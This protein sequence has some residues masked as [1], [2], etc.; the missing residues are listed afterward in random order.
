[1]SPLW[2]DE[3]A[4]YLAPRRVT[5][6][7]LKRGVR[8]QYVKTQDSAVVGERI[9]GWDAAVGVLG[10]CLVDPIW[11]HAACRIIVA[12]HWMRFAIVPWSDALS[13]G[14]ERLLLAQHCLS[15]IYGDVVSQWCVTL[16][17]APPGRPQVACAMPRALL[18]DIERHTESCGLRIRSIQ[19]QL[20]AAFNCRRAQLPS[21]DGW[22]VTLE[23]GS[24]AAA[25]LSQGAW[26]AVRAV[27]TDN[28]WGVELRRLQTE[29]RLAGKE[30]ERIHLDAPPEFR[31][32]VEGASDS[33]VWLGA[34][35]GALDTAS[36]LAL[37]QR[38]YA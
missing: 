10:G 3:I 28:N 21:G 11:N 8:P 23:E 16:N 26:D 2:R 29:S 14:D 36:P 25:H 1:V 37:L 34:A 27:R 6:A 33:V 9:G 7:R 31:A 13:D 35:A 12:N 30:A 22:F 18:E 32:A 4:I 5:L 24:L 19:P 15:K 20:V 38:I 17:E